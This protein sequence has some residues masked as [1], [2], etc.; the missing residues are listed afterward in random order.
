MK[1]IKKENDNENNNQNIIEKQHRSLNKIESIPDEELENNSLKSDKKSKFAQSI[2]KGAGIL[3]LIAVASMVFYIM[4]SSNKSVDTSEDA[5]N[6][7]KEHTSTKLN[8]G[9]KLLENDQPYIG[10]DL[11]IKHNSKKEKTKIY[12]WDYAA[13]DGDYV[14]IIVNGTPLGEPFMIK[15]KP[16]SYTVPTV[17]KVEVLGVR[18]GGGGITYAI[19]YDMNHTT[20]FNGMDIGKNNLYT[21]VRK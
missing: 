18:D 11:T 14:Q 16:V 13:E 19:Y 15:N 12:I 5:I 7:L 21:L 17:G 9:T 3:M 6:A 1:K 20:Y 4:T 8:I 10:G 2:K